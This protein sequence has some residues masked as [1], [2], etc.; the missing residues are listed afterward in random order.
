M[1]TIK[2]KVIKDIFIKN[3]NFNCTIPI[4]QTILF[5]LDDFG[6]IHIIYNNG[7]K[8]ETI[9]VDE[10]LANKILMTLITQKQITKYY[11]D[12]GLLEIILG[13]NYGK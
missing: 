13:I 1:K 3:N 11:E 7:K 9:A 2:F 10:L 12:D 6:Y 5:L 8:I 4:G